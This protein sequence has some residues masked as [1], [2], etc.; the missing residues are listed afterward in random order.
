MRNMNLE[1]YNGKR[2]RV[3]TNILDQYGEYK[4]IEGVLEGQDSI[5]TNPYI[6]IDGQLYPEMCITSLGLVPEK[7]L[8]Q[9][10]DDTVAEVEEDY[11]EAYTLQVDPMDTINKSIE[12]IELIEEYKAK[13]WLEAL[14]SGWIGKAVASLF[15]ALVMVV[16][17]VAST[18]IHHEYTTLPNNDA[19][20]NYT[21]L[22]DIN[23]AC[24]MTSD[25]L[26]CNGSR[27]YKNGNN[28]T[29]TSCSADT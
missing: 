10:E 9:V 13:P 12:E 16:G 18:N 5:G 15:I 1:R 28:L 29:T 6:I 23:K 8:T 14:T 25:G 20:I 27:Y 2:I 4:I 7:V 24:E 19:T 22:Y 11:I 3:Q 17:A 26:C 21:P